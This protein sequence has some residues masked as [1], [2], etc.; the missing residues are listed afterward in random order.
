MR[1]L[2]HPTMSPKM[3]GSF[4]RSFVFTAL[5][6]GL[7]GGVS[8][9][10]DD[11]KNAVDAVDEPDRKTIDV[12]KTG[13]NAFANDPGFGSICDQFQEVKNTLGLSSV[14]ILFSWNDGIQPTPSS[15]PNFSFYDDIAN[16]LPAGVQA[17]AVLTSIPSWMRNS[18]NW[19]NGD[20]RETFV[21][22]WVR[23]VAR[24][25]AGNNRITAF[26]IWNEPNM[27]SD[28][29][30]TTMGLVTNPEAFVAMVAR[31]F[32]EVREVAPGKLVLNGATTAIAQ[33]FPDT[34][35]YNKRMFE[36]GMAEFVD[37]WAI[38]YYG[39]SYERV[40]ARDGVSAF[41]A[42]VPRAVWVTESGRQGVTQQLEYVERTWPFLMEKI[43]SID[44]IFYY[45]HTSADAPESTFAL[46]TRSAAQPFSD[47]YQHLESR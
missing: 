41:L 37:V 12:S 2:Q 47:L 31:G 8:C 10:S 27:A 25:Y 36:A 29:D 17:V 39:K 46:R 32:N 6:L 3:S 14:R 43:P 4:V 24:R 22:L 7:L 15:E 45:Q 30:N 23:R 13:L 42:Q 18:A 26:Q 34:L 21:R 11:I 33:N 35:D 9:N 1:I 19:I 44:K 38:H 20:P 40:T 16:C 28:P 5:A